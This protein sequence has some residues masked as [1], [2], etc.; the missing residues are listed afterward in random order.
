MFRIHTCVNKCEC[1]VNISHAVKLTWVKR[2][3]DGD[4]WDGGGW[5]EVKIDMKFLFDDYG[6]TYTW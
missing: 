3:N 5:V 6:N 1:Y 2:T 4:E